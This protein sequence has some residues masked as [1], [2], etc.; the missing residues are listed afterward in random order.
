MKTILLIINIFFVLSLIFWFLV[1]PFTAFLFDA[2]GN[3][4]K[5]SYFL[6]ICVI[7]YPLPIFIGLIGYLDAYEKNSLI[8]A[9]KYTKISLIGP[10]IIAISTLAVFLFG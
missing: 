10:G 5:T 8:D 2:D 7:F 3:T 4:N 6:G 1:F 9:L